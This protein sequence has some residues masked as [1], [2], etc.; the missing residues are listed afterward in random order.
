MSNDVLSQDPTGLQLNQMP[1]YVCLEHE[2]AT[3]WRYNVT[4]FLSI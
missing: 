3:D 4:R 2:A 1:H